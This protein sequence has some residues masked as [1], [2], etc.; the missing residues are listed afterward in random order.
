MIQRQL[1]VRQDYPERVAILAARELQEKNLTEKMHLME[2]EDAQRRAV[3][4][5]ALADYNDKM[6][7][8]TRLVKEQ[9]L[10]EREAKEREKV[11]KR[12]EKKAE[13]TAARDQK[14]AERLMVKEKEK[15]QRLM[16]QEK[17][18]EKK[19]TGKKKIATITKEDKPA[20]NPASKKKNK[21]STPTSLLT[22][23]KGTKRKVDDLPTPAPKVV[24]TGRGG[25]TV[26]TPNKYK[27]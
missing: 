23:A 7:E 12:E 5:K 4:Q 17:N 24:R 13:A 22:I 1:T 10:K 16:V 6:A 14:K 27:K 19:A 11:R 21:P 9:Q 20:A 8:E 15:A 2:K 18:R 25:R 3:E 26:H